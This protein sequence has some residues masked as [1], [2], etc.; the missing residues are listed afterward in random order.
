MITNSDLQVVRQIV[1]GGLRYHPAKVYLF[2][3]QAKGVARKTSDI[4]IAVW[5]EQPLPDG[6]LSDIRQALE[7]SNILENVD[8]VDLSNADQEFR[9][10]VLK[11]GILW[12]E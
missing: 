12:N 8:L 6:L 4:D 3:S 5:P 1:L 11:E 2:G 7:N 9:L 10:R